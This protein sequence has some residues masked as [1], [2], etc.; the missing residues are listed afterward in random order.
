MNVSNA[1]WHDDYGYGGPALVL[2]DSD[3]NEIVIE[4]GNRENIIQMFRNAFCAND[5]PTDSEI[6]RLPEH[7][8]KML[9]EVRNKIKSYPALK[10]D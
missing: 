4:N 5:A 8:K 7:S 3:L 9:L 2:I 10:T 6:A 1:M